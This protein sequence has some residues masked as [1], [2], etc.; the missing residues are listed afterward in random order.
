MRVVNDET[1]LVGKVKIWYQ[2]QNVLKGED[3]EK[4]C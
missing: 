4:V 2:I 1:K 3:L